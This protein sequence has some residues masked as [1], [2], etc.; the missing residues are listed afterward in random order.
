MGLLN[1]SDGNKPGH[2]LVR[3]IEVV[4]LVLRRHVGIGGVGGLDHHLQVGPVG[5]ADRFEVGVFDE[6]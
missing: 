3:M 4:E 1:D 2:Q 6:L 5:P